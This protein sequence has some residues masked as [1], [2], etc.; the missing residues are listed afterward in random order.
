MVKVRYK[1]N[2]SSSDRSVTYTIL[3]TEELSGGEEKFPDPAGGAFGYIMC[4]GD[5]PGTCW[6]SSVNWLPGIARSLAHHN[7]RKNVCSI[8]ADEGVLY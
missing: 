5:K 8:E 4:A 2:L 6:H 3:E 7:K 1:K